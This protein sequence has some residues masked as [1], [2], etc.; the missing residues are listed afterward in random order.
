MPGL[1]NP[2]EKKKKVKRAKYVAPSQ[3]T[4][5]AKIA[6]KYTAPEGCK[7]EDKLTFSK[8]A[9]LEVELLMNNAIN[10]IVQNADQVLTYSGTATLG[11]QTAE[12][13]TTLALAGLLRDSALKAGSK[14]VENYADFDA[15][16][17]VVPESVTASA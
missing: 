12:I 10:I 13:A 1:P 16:A 17:P 15:A 11:K 8:A 4:Y 7:K 9:I 5:I 6:K 3:T 2:G 14:A